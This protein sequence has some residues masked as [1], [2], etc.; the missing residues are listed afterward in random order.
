MSIAQRSDAET[1]RR[2]RSRQVVSRVSYLRELRRVA[3]DTTQRQL[4]RVIGIFH[5]LSC[6]PCSILDIECDVALDQV[7]CVADGVPGQRRY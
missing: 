3:Q 4:A 7:P 6:D 1:V 2:L 5:Y